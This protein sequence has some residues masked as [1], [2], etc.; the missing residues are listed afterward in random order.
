MERWQ[1]VEECLRVRL[2]EKARGVKIRLHGDLHLGQLLMTGDDFCILD[3]EG[4]PNRPLAE[5]RA[6]DTTLKDV[7]G[8][9]RS[10]DYAARVTLCAQAPASFAR[11]RFAFAQWEHLTTRTFL[12]SYREI[13]GTSLLW[14]RKDAA[15][16]LSLLILEKALY[17]V[18]YEATHRPAWLHIPLAGLHNLACGRYYQ[19]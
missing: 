13:L 2:P 1:Q 7:A 4:E 19:T 3:F 12:A 8:M 17:E 15:R 16:L 11:G 6:K 14:P 10:F 18:I 5:R 9:I